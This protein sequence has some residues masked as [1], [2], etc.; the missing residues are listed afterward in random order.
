M[1]TSVR[2]ASLSQYAAV[3]AQ[4]GLDARAILRRRG[5][6]PRVLEEPETRIPGAAVARAL[7]DAARES[8]C[9]GFALRMA[10]LRHMSDLGPIALVVSHQANIRDV[11]LTITRY[12]PLV[13]ESVALG[14]EEV[15]DVALI[16]ERLLLA[17]PSPQGDELVLGILF[18]LFRAV[19][20]GS[21]R[22]LSVHFAHPEPDDLT[23]HR[24]M[25]GAPLRFGAEF[26][27]FTCRREDLDAANP[28]ADPPL[29]RLA[30]DLIQALPY[31]RPRPIGQEV[32]AAILLLLPG[33]I[34][35]MDRVSSMLGLS[36]RTLQRRLAAVGEEFAAL[37][38]HARRDLAL[39]YLGD[40]DRPLV[41]VAALVGYARQSSFSRWFADEFGESPTAWREARAA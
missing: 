29:A 22:P 30:E 10:E 13:S 7:E 14:F 32:R 23:V 27:G 37:L 4:Y 9:S 18:R 24:R 38:K 19:L 2:A 40:R 6:D 20:Q 25:F 41:D 15:G 39:R 17:A 3:A 8:G 31:A 33:E 26:N 36:P 5:I 34:P 21:W 1:S 35:S 16:H 28:S 11:L 12:A